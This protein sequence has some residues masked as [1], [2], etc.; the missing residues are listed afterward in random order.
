MGAWTTRIMDD[1]GV[2]D[3]I[4]EYKIL[5]GYGVQPEDAYKAIY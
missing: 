5:M 1:D 4:D 3:I 2:R